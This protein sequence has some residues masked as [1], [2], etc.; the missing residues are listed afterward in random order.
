MPH[1]RD[2]DGSDL[3]S[4]ATQFGVNEQFLRPLSRAVR[5]LEQAGELSDD[6][7]AELLKATFESG[8]WPRRGR[9]KK[10]EV[11]VR[12][13]DLGLSR[14][15]VHE[16]SRMGEIPAADFDAFLARRDAEGKRITRR[17]ILV[18]FGKINV[19]S[20]DIFEGTPTGELAEFLLRPVERVFEELEKPQRRALLHALRFRLRC[21]TDQHGT[22]TAMR[23][24]AVQ[25]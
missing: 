14:Q 24:G 20:E 5:A 23:S 7:R 2:D 4:T 11:R 21:I 25:D 22:P 10:G 17:S 16:W 6:E 3:M 8:Q 19:R 18:H 9:P 1:E 12:W 15:R 13:A